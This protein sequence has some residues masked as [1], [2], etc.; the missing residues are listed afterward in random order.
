VIVAIEL[1]TV[2]LTSVWKF[3]SN[4][5]IGSFCYERQSR[6]SSSKARSLLAHQKPNTDSI[7]F[8]HNSNGSATED[9]HPRYI[10]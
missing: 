5:R 1:K 3:S 6:R 10:I 2:V 9:V 7:K 4:L 8:T